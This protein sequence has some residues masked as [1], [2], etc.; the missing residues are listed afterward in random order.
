MMNRMKLEVPEEQPLGK[1]R[2]GCGGG[3]I[4]YGRPCIFWVPYLCVYIYIYIQ[5]DISQP[6]HPTPAVADIL[7][8]C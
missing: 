4:I 8:T 6:L 3:G 1:K 2:R 7:G 5:T